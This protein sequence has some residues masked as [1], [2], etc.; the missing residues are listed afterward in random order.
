M[1]NAVL[2]AI[3]DRGAVSAHNGLFQ[4][5]AQFPV[6]FSGFYAASEESRQRFDIVVTSR[7]GD[8]AGGGVGMVFGGWNIHVTS[9]LAGNI[10]AII[11]QF[12]YNR[13]SVG[14][15]CR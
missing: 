3:G 2:L 15:L 8:V 13:P 5:D 6:R 14:S 10:A 11:R 7:L 9:S 1:R 4:L 12:G